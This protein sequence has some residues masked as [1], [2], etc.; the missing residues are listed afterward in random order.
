MSVA[1]ITLPL[2]R[3]EGDLEARVDVRD[4]AVADAWCSG[5]LY[6]GFERILIGR[7]ALDGL[8]L[9]PRICGICSV[10]QLAAA[11][12][13]LD[14]IVG[15]DIPPGATAVRN[16]C[17]I[18]E[19][20]QSNMRHSFLGF[21]PD[22]VHPAYTDRP[23]FVEAVARYTSLGGS[24][25]RRTIEETKRALEIIAILGGQW[26]HPSFMVPGG[27]SSVPSRADLLQC[28][29]VLGAFRSWYESHVLGSPIE[30]WREIGDLDGFLTWLD[31]SPE[32]ASS[33]VGFFWRYGLDIGL[34]RL[35]RG[36]GPM[37]G[38]GGLP[39]PEGSR[40]VAAPGGTDLLAGGLLHRGGREEFDESCVT[41]CDAHSWLVHHPDAH[42][43]QGKTEPYA[44][45]AEGEGYTWAK[46]PRYRGL[47]AETG[48]LADLLLLG[49]PLM[50]DLVE[51][52]GVCV[53]T[54]QLARLLSPTRLLPAALVW[55]EEA[56][57]AERF[58]RSPGEVPDGEGVGLVQAP[59]GS[60]G[61]WGRV[62]DGRI[63]HYQIITPTTWNAS[64][65]D[66][67]NVRGPMEQALLGTPVRD[68]E[69]PVEI[70][71][72]VRSFD[73]CL[74]CTVHALRPAGRARGGTR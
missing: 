65:R 15:V 64:P 74:V 25:C 40:V 11:A 35:G 9:T 22:L 5:T 12:A 70:G 3:V 62:E 46:A 51:R 49:D 69:S 42:P 39:V 57:E 8:V 71:H 72:V 41:E 38:Y 14:R 29:H 23:L 60:L 10:S 45:G 2:N 18:V 17:L 7:G 21:A 28:R 34:D 33:E 73:P 13:A 43:R 36:E 19:H 31:G 63:A 56:G 68:I 1:R 30:E 47:P 66:S 27:I 48:P 53:L 52:H 24:A 58:Y 54:R 67:E 20:L 55:L 59:R 32:H 37:I 26:P 16:V 61:H 6:R 50:T 44:S 4:G